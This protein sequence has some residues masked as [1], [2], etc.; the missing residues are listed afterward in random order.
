MRR[1]RFATRVAVRIG[2][3][4]LSV[5]CFGQGLSTP[6]PVS[7]KGV[8]SDPWS[9]Y[10]WKP[11][12]SADAYF[13]QIRAGA[14]PIKV[15]S[16][17]CSPNYHKVAGTQ[18]FFFKSS[19][20]CSA[21]TCSVHIAVPAANRKSYSPATGHNFDVAQSG[22]RTACGAT[23][24]PRSW[25]VQAMQGPPPS[26]FRQSEAGQGRYLQPWP[27]H[28]LPSDWLKYWLNR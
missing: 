21:T 5:G 24:Y 26:R 14:E 6:V 17:D 20:V 19:A 3:F 22:L 16:T 10:E 13:L 28:S 27:N 9:T 1:R 25:N 12:T 18:N 8:T 23:K 11:I 2:I 4:C 15:G 7:P